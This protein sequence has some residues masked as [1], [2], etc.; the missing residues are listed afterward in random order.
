MQHSIRPVILSGGSGTRMWP[1]SRRARPKQFHPLASQKTMLQETVLRLRNDAADAPGGG[2]GAGFLAPILLASTA[3]RDL[4]VE[5]LRAVNVDPAMIILEPMAKNTAPAIAALAAAA[6]RENSGEI[7][8]ILP[9]DH[10]IAPADAFREILRKGAVAAA[11]G[12]I[13]TFGVEP[14]RPETGYG[15]I[16]AGE[17]LDGAASRVGAFVEKPALETAKAYLA[18]GDYFWN[19]GIFMFRSDVMIEQM[20][21]FCPEILKAAQEAV[22]R[23]ARSGPELRLDG[24]AFSAAPEESID[25]AVMEHTDAAAVVPAGVDWSDIGSWGALWEIADKDADGNAHAGGEPLF[26]D[27]ANTL[28]VSDG[29]KIAAVGIEDLIIVATADGVLVAPRERSQDV[30]K[31][32]ERL[33]AGED[34]N[35]L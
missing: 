19:A 4:V 6:E 32:V 11:A 16:R 24:E 15:Y 1:L 2:E 20:R 23:G 14:T 10:V 21:K 5:Q 13:V 26:L 30:K 31:I 29:P 27:C 25:Y 34:T 22:L 8:V 12:S 7:L 35:L 9:A 33:K 28:A 18:S 17:A 3:H